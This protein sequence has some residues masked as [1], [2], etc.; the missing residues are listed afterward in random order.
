MS[1][2]KKA[3]VVDDDKKT[4]MFIEDILTPL[5]FHVF[6]AEEGKE[7]LELVEREKPDIFVCDLLLPGI[8]GV[9]VCKMVKQNPALDNVKVIA[10]SAVYNESYY[11]RALDCPADAFIEKPFSTKNFERLI[12]VVENGSD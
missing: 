7:A 8:H 4:T 10:I 2:N 1:K 11:K 5:G 3:V 6:C 12:E 9:E